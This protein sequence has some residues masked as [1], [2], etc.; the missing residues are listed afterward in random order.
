[1]IFITMPWREEIVSNPMI[2]SAH[3]G[4]L[5]SLVDLTGLYTLLAAGVAAS[6][7]VGGGS[8]AK[9]PGI[10][11]ALAQVVQLF[12]QGELP[13]EEFVKRKAALLAPAEDKQPK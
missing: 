11:T 1:M 6:D 13:F 7:A 5:A 8:P 3:G 10:G 9:P 12:G 2:G 4:I